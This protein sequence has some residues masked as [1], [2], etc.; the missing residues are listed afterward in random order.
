[1][2]RK[3][4]VSDGERNIGGEKKHPA[5]KRV[6]LLSPANAS[7]A[8]AQMILN[9]RAQFH[10]AARLREEGLPLGEIFSFISGLYFRGKLAYV[11]AFA[12]DHNGHPGS[13]VIT[14]GGGLISPET[15]LTIEQL[16]GISGVAIAA[17]EARYREPLERDAR[18]LLKRIGPDCEVVLLGSV[19]TPKYVE[20]LLAIFG[21]R[22]MFPAEFA[23]RGDMSR[24][25]LMLRCV[26]FEACLAVGQSFV[27]DNTNPLPADRARYIGPARTAGFR[28]I[29]YFFVTP[30]REAMR[31]NNLRIL[32]QKIPAVAVAG[33]YKKLQKPTLEEGFDEVHTVELTPEDKFLI[34]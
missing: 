6:F 4:I 21:E 20:P 28:L 24:G 12:T 10:L 25:G 27:V 23:G 9:D 16:R 26:L 18:K 33:T 11:C 30:L 5:P 31:R 3:T 32:K 17:S 7:G 1:V 2:K 15:R 13:F 29:A 34:D 14:A 19:A 22:L 8:R